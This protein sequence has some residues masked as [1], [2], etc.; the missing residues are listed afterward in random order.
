MHF[1]KCFFAWGVK[2]REEDWEG[3]GERGFLLFVIHT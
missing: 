1:E 3:K 2:I